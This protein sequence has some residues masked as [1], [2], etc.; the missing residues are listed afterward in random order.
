MGVRC[1]LRLPLLV[2]AFAAVVAAALFF[3][4]FESRADPRETDNRSDFCGDPNR[5]IECG[6]VCFWADCAHCGLGQSQVISCNNTTCCEPDPPPVPCPPLTNPCPPQLPPGNCDDCP[7]SSQTLDHHSVYNGITGHDHTSPPYPGH[8]LVPAGHRVGEP[9]SGGSVV[10]MRPEPF[11]AYHDV[12]SAPAS[13]PC[14]LVGNDV[15]LTY[16]YD[17]DTCVIWHHF[18]EGG[19]PDDP[20]LGLGGGDQDY[21]LYAATTFAHPAAL[22]A[23]LELGGNEFP[24][25]KCRPVIG[26]PEY[27][28]AWIETPT[29]FGDLTIPTEEVPTPFLTRGYYP[30]PKSVDTVAVRGG[31]RSTDDRDP[32]TDDFIFVPDPWLSY[33]GAGSPELDSAIRITDPARHRFPEDKDDPWYDITLSD[34]AGKVVHYRYWLDNGVIPNLILHPFRPLSHSGGLAEVQVELDDVIKEGSVGLIAFQLGA[35]GPEGEVVDWSNVVQVRVGYTEYLVL[36][37]DRDG[38]TAVVD[39]VVV[40]DEA[41]RDWVPEYV[42][43]YLSGTQMS[44]HFQRQRRSEAATPLPT[45]TPPPPPAVWR[46]RP[47]SPILGSVTPDPLIPGKVTLNLSGGYSGRLE[48]RA[49][50]YSGFRRLDFEHHVEWVR[51]DIPASEAGELVLYDLDSLVTW[52][53][54]VRAIDSHGIVGNPSPAYVYKLWDPINTPGFGVTRPNSDLSIDDGDV[55][56]C[57][58]EWP[59]FW[60]YLADPVGSRLQNQNDEN[61]PP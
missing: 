45:L 56:R 15:D 42:S 6:D 8:G 40:A 31:V 14:S 2:A 20:V 49:Y 17:N 4:A 24:L 52:E 55:R 18:L 39:G 61:I 46:V 19:D 38:F 41:D 11:D 33:A 35:M 48:Y 12:P 3:P 59:M 9:L 43:D 60:D 34:Y 22:D 1:S 50:Y 16:Y 30:D 44:G 21:N 47:V 13:S 36:D 5:V 7:N 29:P 32:D 25:Y 23:A 57:C 10:G 58:V 37:Q 51:R 28:A 26:G 53:F 27:D 54:E